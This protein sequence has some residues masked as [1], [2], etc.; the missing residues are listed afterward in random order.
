VGMFGLEDPNA[1]GYLVEAFDSRP[2]DVQFGS[3]A[4]CQ[5]VGGDTGRWGCECIAGCTVGAPLVQMKR[6]DCLLELIEES[7]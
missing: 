6:L 7:Q 4:A 5:V 2:R 3:S 1:T